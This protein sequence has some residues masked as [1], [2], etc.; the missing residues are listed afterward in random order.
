M[1]KNFLII[2][3]LGKV[4]PAVF[5]NQFV[6]STNS[7]EAY[8]YFIYG[9][10]AYYKNDYNTARDWFLQALV[11]DSNLVGALAKI[12]TSYFNEFRYEEG[13]IW[14][15]RYYSKLDMMTMQQKIW[16]N[17]L[18]AIYFNT[19]NERIRYLRQ[20][21]DID[22]HQPITYFQIGDSYLEMDQ[23]DKAIPESEK[24]LE[25]FQK[26]DA[27]PPWIAYYIELGQAYHKSGKY[28]EEKKLY[29][30]AEKDFPDDPELLDQQAWLA[31]TEGD[32]VTANRKIRKYISIRKEQSWSEAKIAS[33]V[34]YI[35]YMSD[36]PGKAEEY[37]R[38]ALSLEPE[39]PLRLTG[40]AYFLIDKERNINEGLQLV[41]KALELNPDSYYSFHCKGW[42]LHKLG[43]HKEALEFLEKSMDL[44]PIYRYI[45]AQ[46]LEEVKKAVAG[47]N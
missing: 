38:Q 8:R 1:V 43:K 35:Y 5:H 25:I 28:K 32:T 29:R 47:Q 18:Y 4:G 40:L 24:A 2:S 21:I 3:K 9:Q 6:S 31:L 39:N 46:H 26:W 20:L 12:S 44:N 27:K 42:G 11:I 45:I 10:T 14:C 7:P 22:D 36:I 33:N 19:P 15:L 16:A 17:V 37:Y 30:K 23:F 13:K 34:A 41:D